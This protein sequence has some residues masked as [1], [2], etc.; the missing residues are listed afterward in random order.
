VLGCSAGGDEFENAIGGDGLG[1]E[2]QSGTA[3]Q[4]PL[5]EF[6]GGGVA[7][8]E[9]DSAV[10][11]VLADVIGEFDA[12]DRAHD[13]IRDHGV[14]SDAVGHLYGRFGAVGRSRLVSAGFQD[15]GQAVGH[16]HIV[17]NYQHT[18]ALG[19]IRH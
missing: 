19:L 6:T 11:E 18:Q 2:L 9:Q 16:T 4:E 15:L 12:T 5:G 13:D 7:G 3:R 14:R 17:I 10:G 8:D 1:G